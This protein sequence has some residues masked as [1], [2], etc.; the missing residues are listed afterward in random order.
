M[1]DSIPYDSLMRHER[2]RAVMVYAR[3]PLATQQ[4]LRGE[5]LQA[6]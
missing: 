4:T 5:E 6:L 2:L 3:Y 1:K